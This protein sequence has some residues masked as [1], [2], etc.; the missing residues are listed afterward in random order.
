MAAIQSYYISAAK[1]ACNDIRNTLDGNIHTL[2][3]RAQSDQKLSIDPSLPALTAV[4]NILTPELGVL[5]L[6]A[7]D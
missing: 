6:G 1:V 4:N 3:G 2:H 7:G 5:R